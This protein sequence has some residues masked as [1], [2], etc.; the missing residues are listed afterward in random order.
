MSMASPSEESPRVGAAFCTTQWTVV[1]RA[2]GEAAA[3]SAAALERLCTA[4]WPPVYAHI[5]RRGHDAEAAR[6]AT[7]EFFLRLIEGD[8]LRSADPAR[9]RFRT[10][11][12]TCLNR[13]LVSEWR[14]SSS[15]KR[16][17]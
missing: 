8:W 5:R 17:G 4:Y 15:Q 3:D 14:R 12:L 6:D 7:Q 11:L 10:F 1:I 16:G 9:G 13:F 2:G